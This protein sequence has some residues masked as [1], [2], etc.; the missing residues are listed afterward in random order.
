MKTKFLNRILILLS[1]TCLQYLLAS[2]YCIQKCLVDSCQSYKVQKDCLHKILQELNEVKNNCS[3]KY[4]E[5]CL[6]KYCTSDECRDMIDCSEDCDYDFLQ[7]LDFKFNLKSTHKNIKNNHHLIK[8]YEEQGI[9]TNVDDTFIDDTIN[10][11][12]GH[13][14]H[15]RRHG[16]SGQVLSAILPIILIIL[17]TLTI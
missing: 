17:Y 11:V 16:L 14:G 4:A 15:N 1:A 9:Q 10:K 13:H 12:R 5:S 3:P 2:N 7:V 8:H 6:Q